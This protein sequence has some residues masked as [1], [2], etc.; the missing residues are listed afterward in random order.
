MLTPA[1]DLV[2]LLTVRMPKLQILHLIAIELVDGSWEGVVECMK[3][4]MHLRGLG[5]AMKELADRKLLELYVLRGGR[6]PRLFPDEPDSASEKY[7]S[8]PWL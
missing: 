3:R 2:R 6:H 7:M 5:L 8:A 1:K 4:S